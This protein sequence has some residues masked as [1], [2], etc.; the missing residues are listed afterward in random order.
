[1]AQDWDLRRTVFGYE[2]KW[3]KEFCLEDEPDEMEKGNQAQADPQPPETS[4]PSG[5]AMKALQ[6]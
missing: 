4:R 1:M 3:K 6:K 2:V 5:P